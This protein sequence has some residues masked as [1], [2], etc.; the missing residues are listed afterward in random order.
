MRLKKIILQG[1]KSFA[2]RT[3]IEFHHGVTGIVGPNGCGKSNIADAFRWVLGEK[4][5]KSMRGKEMT[6]VIFAGSHIRKPLNFAEVTLVLSEIEGKLPIEYEEVAVT[7]RLHRNGESEY[8]IN[9]HPVRLKDV[10]S[11]FLDTGI[12]KSAFSV[13][14]QG[15]ID[16][17]I[18]Y[19]PLERR[20]IFEEAAGILRFLERKREALKK[21]QQTDENL[22]RVKDIHHEVEQQITVLKEQA[23]KAQSYKENKSKLDTLEK[24]LL[25]AKWDLNQTKLS[26]R[27]GLEEEGTERLNRIQ[28]ELRDKLLQ[29]HQA[30]QNLAEEEDKYRKKNEDV[31]KKRN[32]KEL[33]VQEKKS[34]EERLQDAAQQVGKW[35]KDLEQLAEKKLGWAQEI[36]TINEKQ[37]KV[38][39]QIAVLDAAHREQVAI[40]A[41]LEAEV[42]EQSHRHQA[43]QSDLF[44]VI[45]KENSIGSDLKQAVVRLEGQLERKGRLLE[46]KEKLQKQ[47]ETTK[48]ELDAKKGELEAISEKI[49]LKKERFQQLEESHKDL[50]DQI[51]EKQKQGDALLLN[52]TEGEARLKVL[53]RLREDFEGFSSGTKQLLKESLRQGCPF[54][55]KLKPIHEVILPKEGYEEILAIL[56]KPYSQTIVVDSSEAY[57][58]VLAFAAEKK[59]QDYSIFCSEH[60]TPTCRPQ[61]NVPQGLKPLIDCVIENPVATHFFH[62][63]YRCSSLNEAHRAI[64]AFE[65]IDIL[66]GNGQYVDRRQVLFHSSKSENNAFLREAE[67]K[68]LTKKIETQLAERSSLEETIKQLTH[69]KHEVQTQRVELDKTIRQDEMKHVEYN[70]TLQRFTADLQKGTTEEAQLE[71]ELKTI[72]TACNALSVQKENLE[73]QLA[74]AAEQAEQ[75]REDIVIMKSDLDGL[76]EKWKREQGV[77]KEKH[78]AH[79]ASIDEQRRLLHQ[80]QMIEVK[81]QESEETEARLQEEIADQTEFQSEIL[82]KGTAFDQAIAEAEKALQS[83]L[84]LLQRLETEL[85]QRRKII[86][87]MEHELEVHQQLIKKIEKEMVQI[88]L[89]SSQIQTQIEAI[90][91]ELKERHETTVAA[92]RQQI[93]ASGTDLEAMGN[94]EQIEKEVRRLRHWIEEAGPI[95]MTSIEDFEKQKVRYDFLINQ[96]DDIG[97]SKDELMQIVTEL[98]TESRK[99][100]KSVFE[101]IR[102]NFQKNFALLF[103]GGEAD[104]CF[105]DSDDVLEAGIEITAKPPGK[106]MRSINLLSGG[107][108]C[109]TALALLFAIFE[110]KPAPFCLLDEIDAPLDDSNIERFVNVVKQFIVHCQFIIITHNKRTMAIADVLFGVSMQERGV[111]KL[112]SFEFS[113]EPTEA[114]E[115]PS[116][117]V[118]LVL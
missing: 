12:G 5:A 63:L 70:F 101:Q 51:N 71:E 32:E 77:L 17:V 103:T 22:S 52:L 13:F 55:G 21:L 78:A 86:E 110:V 67:I 99:I 66:L 58:N 25:C 64:A 41:K 54:F 29:L 94:V 6:D 7:R 113:S 37:K 1:F 48:W 49:D 83:E 96:M 81:R 87:K 4:S 44:R 65:G 80:K 114:D 43:I 107:E 47:I 91:A 104:L 74:A 116:P 88:T 85:N 19:T 105:I 62:S 38:E 95:N 10:H 117:H 60:H 112:L 97:G 34:T 45:N 39:E 15:K 89:S 100:F 118:D 42:V 108:K 23:A 28:D 102:R 56:M 79:T 75:A 57:E 90:E 61:A 73:E 36:Q 26:E 106:Q 2:D 30:K 31:Y 33:K 69:R 18:N 68:E 93:T 98:D 115:L 76:T 72:L 27:K 50:L 14:E 16:Q 82:S 111:S 35:R 11:L 40:V 53:V 3:V 109:L 92:V 24:G 8:F 9:R 20:T 46:K 84:K 59:I